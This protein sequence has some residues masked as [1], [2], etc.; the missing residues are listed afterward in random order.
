MRVALLDV[1]RKLDELVALAT[2][3]RRLQIEYYRTRDKSLLPNC[4][5]KERQLDLML[6]GLRQEPP[7]SEK[8]KDHV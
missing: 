8:G 2:E 1:E 4:K 6:A 5:A 7:T 3:V